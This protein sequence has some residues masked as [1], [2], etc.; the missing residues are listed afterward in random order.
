MAG[1]KQ[2]KRRINSA[3][4]ISQITKAMEAVAASKMQKAQA[5]A[6]SGEPYQKTLAEITANLAKQLHPKAH[7][8]LQ[9]SAEQTLLPKLYLI[10]SSDKGLCGGF[11]SNLFRLAEQIV[12]EN[13]PVVLL[14]KKADIY[15]HKTGWRAIGS[16]SPLGDTP[17]YNAIKPAGIIAIEEFL[18]KQ[19]SGVIIIYQKFINTL[20]QTST[21]D[22]ILPVKPADAFQSKKEI[23][24]D[25]IFET[26]RS[27]L[28]N[29]VLPYYIYLS[30]YQAVLSSKAAEQSAR[31]V[32]M[33][34]ASDNADQVKSDLQL[35]YNRERQEAITSEIS[36]VVTAS[37]ALKQI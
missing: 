5:A 26:S 14:G 32:A 36:D 31:M 22:Q 15:T 35:V 11:N 21:A 24:Q 33:K 23:N 17:T 13:D 12:K 1:N 20:I 29:D 7:P 28:L 10:I 18:K 9:I 3:N 6:V 4:N 34:S 37:M 2:L 27:Q 8:L 25:Y 30:I 16:I 19:T